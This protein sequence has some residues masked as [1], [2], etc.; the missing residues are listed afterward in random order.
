[1]EAPKDALGQM[2]DIWA[3]LYYHMAKTFCDRF[4]LEGE[5]ALRRAVRE[6]G[7]ARGL[8]MRARH[9][10]EG[11]PINLES[12]FGHYDLPSDPR[13]SRNLFELTPETRLSATKTCQ[14]ADLWMEKEDGDHLG[15]IYCEEV[16][17]AIFE[18]YDSAVQV[19]LTQT[20][21][22]GDDCCRFAVYLRPANQLGAEQAVPRYSPPEY[23]ETP[24]TRITDLFIALY[25]H[26]ARE[27][28]DTF[29]N[30]GERAL[31]HAIR[32]FGAERGRR[33][34]KQHEEEGLPINL[35]TLH[36]QDTKDRPADPRTEAVTHKL[37]PGVRETD[38]S[39]C[40]FH[41]AWRDWGGTDVA[42]IYCQE[43]HHAMWQ[44]YDPEI[45]VNLP[46]TLTNGDDRCVF[47]VY[48]PE[49]REEE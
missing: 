16:H 14:F 8:A 18:A 12:L 45:E 47:R 22:Q 2:G 19:N 1:M 5:A 31:R 7:R 30:E 25:Y 6:Y 32:Q 13:T 41:E 36:G 46:K 34:R 33:M 9:L 24:I 37:T 15:R 29:G 44:A 26:M 23:E 17:H 48:W 11:R 35:V 10:A 39:K 38:V 27:M 4:G 20:L 28:V 49:K 40:G 21:T 42:L 43:V 3:M